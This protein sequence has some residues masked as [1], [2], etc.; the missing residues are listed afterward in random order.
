MPAAG[1]PLTWAVIKTALFEAG[2]GLALSYG[3]SR[4]SSHFARRKNQQGAP[5]EAQSRLSNIV[6]TDEPMRIIYGRV[7]VGGLVAYRNNQQ[8]ED[9]SVSHIVIVWC[10]HRVDAVLNHF[11]DG[12]EIV[13]AD[14]DGAG[15][16]TAG[17]FAAKTSIRRY[18][19]TQFAADPMLMDAF[20]EWSSNHIGQ[21]RS[22]S[23][24]RLTRDEVLFPNG[25]PDRI[26]ALIRGRRV[27]D[28]R[29]DS[30][31]GGSGPQQVTLPATW[32]WSNNPALCLRDYLTDSLL[33]MGVPSSFIDPVHLSTAANLCEELVPIPGAATQ[34]RYTSDIVL[35]TDTNHRT[36]IEHILGAMLGT[37]V[38]SGTQMFMYGGSYDPPLMDL[39]EDDLAGG[40]SGRQITPTRE[41]NNAVRAVYVD[42]DRKSQ[43]NECQ[44]RTNPTYESED[45]GRRLW[46]K[47]DLPAVADEYRAQRI[48]EVVLRESRD[49]QR[50]TIPV[51]LTVGLRLAT[52]DKIRWSLGFLGWI[53][54]S[55]RI[56][57][58]RIRDDFRVDLTVEEE[59]DNLYDWIAGDAIPVGAHAGITQTEEA[60]PAP[61]DLTTTPV[62]EGIVLQW[63]SPEPGTHAVIDVWADEDPGFASPGIVFSG[64]ASAFTHLVGGDVTRYYRIRA[65]ATDGGVSA[66]LPADPDPPLE[67][68]SLAQAAFGGTGVNVMPDGY[69]MFADN[70]LPPMSGANGTVTRDT[71]E[72][73]FGNGSLK[74]VATASDAYVYLA[75][76]P[77]AYNGVCQA[78]KKWIVSV[79]VRC[80]V[81][82]TNLEIWLKT[83]NGISSVNLYSSPTPNQWS[84]VSAI[85]DLSA[86]NA[87]EF[88]IRLDN[89]ISGRT[90]WIDGLMVEARVGTLTTPSP[91]ALPNRGG[92]WFAQDDEPGASVS[93]FG[94]HWLDTNDGNRHYRFDGANWVDFRDGG[95]QAALDAAAASQAA[96]DGKITSFWSDKAPSIGMAPD[97]AA[98]GDIWFD[99]DAGNRV[100]RVVGGAWANAQDSE[101]ARAIADAATAQSTADG[102]ITTFFQTGA[103]TIGVAPDFAAE[104]DLWADTD[105]LN[106][107]YRLSSGVWED[108]S[109]WADLTAE[110]LGGL[111]VN[112]ILEGYSSFDEADLPAVV[113]NS[114]ATVTQDSA[115][116][117]FGG[118][119]L[120]IVADVA[121][122]WCYLSPGNTT[123]NVSVPANQKWIFSVFVRSDTASAAL[124]LWL[125][126]A[127]GP[128]S[129]PLTTSSTP[130]LW[131]RVWAVFDMTTNPNNALNARVDNDTN[132]AVMWFDGIMLEPMVGNLEQP[133]QYVLP[134][135]QHRWFYQDDAP[136]SGVARYGDHW[137]DTNDGNLH[138]R[139]SGTAW[140]D[141]QD[142]GI[143]NALDAAAASQAAADGK[144]VTYFQ[145]TAPAS[146]GLGDLWF[147]TDDGNRVYRYD[148]ASWV[149]SQDDE[150]A[151]AILDAATAQATADGKITTYFQAGAPTIGVAPDNAAV[152]DL[153]VDTNDRNRPYR[154]DGAIWIDIS[155]WA[156]LTADQL[157][158]TGVNIAPF[159]YAQYDYPTP[160]PISPSNAGYSIAAAASAIGFGWLRISP[161]AAT[162]YLYLAKTS[163]TYNAVI[164]PNKKWLLSAFVRGSTGSRTGRLAIKAGNG[165]IFSASFTTHATALVGTRVAVEL[166]LTSNSSETALIRIG[167]DGTGAYIEFDGIMLEELLGNLTSASAYAEPAGNHRTFRQTNQPATA[168]SRFGDLWFDTDDDNHIYY[169][170]GST[171]QNSRDGGIAQAVADAAASLAAVDGKI[172]SFWKTTPPSI[173]IAPDNA[174]DGDIWFDT[175]AGNKIHR[176]VGGVWTDA[177]DDEI[178]QA[179]LDAA[180]AQSTADGK[181]T[182]FF[183]TG[184]PTIGVAP[185]FAAEGDLWADTD[186]DNKPY[187]CNGTT[188]DDLGTWADFTLDQIGGT[189]VN[190]VPWG[191]SKFVWPTP[192]PVA[193]KSGGGVTVAMLA[194][195]NTLGGYRLG[196]SVTVSDGYVYLS[197]SSALYNGSC[198]PNQKHI[199][200]AWVLSSSGTKSGQL[201]VRAS[202]GLEYGYTFNA[203]SV[204]T[205]VS[206]L[207]DLSSNPSKRFN[208]RI[209][210]NAGSGTIDFDGI[211][212]EPQ[213]GNLETAS[214]YSPP[215]SP[216]Q[217]VDQR[218]LPPIST[219]NRNGIQ[220]WS[221]GGNLLTGTDAGSTA[222]ITVKAHSV[223]YGF[224]TV[225]YNSGTIFGNSFLTEIHVYCL[226][227]DLAG[228]A[229]SYLATTDPSVVTS[230]IG[231][232][233]VGTISTPADG[234]SST[235][236]GSG[237]GCVAVDSYLAEAV[238]AKA[239]RPGS[240]ITTIHD[241]LLDMEPIQGVGPVATV[242]CVRLTTMGGAELV[243]SEQTPITFADGSQG[244]AL[245]ARG[246]MVTTLCGVVTRAETVVSVER[247]GLQEVM[248]LTA[249][250][251][252]FAAGQ[253]PGHMIFTHNGL[254]GPP[255]T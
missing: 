249:G 150:I 121:D 244:L 163:T 158:G 12:D 161:T 251:L 135:R 220:T 204:W 52:H 25:I 160:P 248:P 240:L 95:I 36:N 115:Q 70:D 13:D 44:P 202:N 69:S 37:M 232:Y 51:K 151:R 6:A 225:S 84:R 114:G 196:V 72:Y 174:E 186:D 171:W 237:A 11:I 99:T 59:A 113:F 222:T 100:S 235:G 206:G 119:S 132:G 92:Y 155:D 71:T 180:T 90:M 2:I 189:G 111:G 136:G 58:W 73:L 147:D 123:Y 213:F 145:T 183:Q 126:S 22:Y 193:P 177:Q 190:L 24:I 54:K 139:Y 218:I 207:L 108:I 156:D 117:V 75:N 103:P 146:P 212:I 152:G 170:D 173:G 16:V 167:S 20:S 89:N 236:G 53:Q 63:T 188:W 227:A 131:T 129:Q 250:G 140:V 120:K 148:G 83:P 246:R 133:S 118:G 214:D 87:T 97:N 205:R 198:Q 209:A 238:Q 68:T 88:L 254:K 43:T 245:H 109:S 219:S 221:G 5:S 138:Y 247:I 191:Y 47:I 184:A 93:R 49:Q 116:S 21:Q 127:A 230:K 217:A 239:A 82:S 80:D 255:P 231:H 34:A 41:L 162:G 175:D 101:I 64:M 76:S 77:T 203:T 85:F 128:L 29:Q 62:P 32:T 30:T 46:K 27:Y 78:N 57:N 253:H 142:A 200:S 216:T 48:A 42:P 201:K 159:G 60:P 61:T 106:R 31:V 38:L 86:D 149:D 74:I 65:R 14:I 157:G 176:L 91:Y 81:S 56:T 33:G 15:N 192:P 233:Y 4:I 226:D 125:R 45:N 96:A 172:T 124:T 154:C 234:G 105:D 211:M 166:D 164:R 107:P 210:N 130:N 104:G 187:R 178:A 39:T 199:I 50:Y 18:D 55:L 185:D 144:I 223:T 195:S 8:I 10:A 67:E 137:I 110:N 102:K 98:E 215:A 252:A 141:I 3:L 165:V 134:Q 168:D 26:Q 35:S 7:R 224:G 228:G 241:G 19:G 122:S 1:V 243:C 9:N 94:D 182:T 197:A 169:F 23:A 28:P 242:L 17:K 112:Y 143:Q 181:I 79:F 229:V 40:I 66:F 153:W 194:D 179:I 208:V